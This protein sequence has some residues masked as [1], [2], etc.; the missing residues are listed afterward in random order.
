MNNDVY[1]IIPT[2]DRN[3]DLSELL[4]SLRLNGIDPFNTL[5]INNGGPLA[6]WFHR[7]GLVV[8]DREDTPHIYQQW[9]AGLEWAESR[10]G[11]G[12]SHYVMILNDDVV[13]PRDFVHDCLYALNRTSATIAYPNQHNRPSDLYQG[14]S[15][16]T[17]LE[18]RVTGYAFMVSGASGIRL[19]EDFKWW[20]GDDDLDWRARADYG[21]TVLVAETYVQ[22]K[23]PSQST[24]A[25]AERSAQA[26]RDRETFIKKHGVAPW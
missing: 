14:H 11:P 19:D 13:L 5:I 23:Y 20:Y 2:K 10:W 21:G 15:G 8:E 12:M 18:D 24:N 9:N 3:Y 1:A 22:H 7:Q 26:G 4:D 6:T 16:P 17:S 25:S